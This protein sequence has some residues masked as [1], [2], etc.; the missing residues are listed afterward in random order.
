MLEN[1]Q[2]FIII[3]ASIALFVFGLQSFSKEIENLGTEKLSKWI[4]KITKLPLGGFLLG[5]LFTSIVQSSTLVSTLTVSLVNT[6]I[7]TFRD[8]IL[9]MLGTNIGNTST[10]WIVSMNSSFLGPF[11]IVLG[12]VISMIPTKIAVAGKSV[13]YFGFIFFSLSFISQAMEPIKND[14]LLVNIL[15]KASNPLLGIIYGIII[16]ITIQSS[17]VVVGLVIVLLSQG[18]IDIEVAIPI[19]IGANIGTTSTALLVSLKFSSLS[20]LVAWSASAFNIVGVIIML[21]F[22]GV[23]KNIALSFSDIPA[24]QVA[25]AFTVSNTFTSLFFLLFINPT[26]RRLQKHKWYRQSFEQPSEIEITS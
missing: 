20:K 25:M 19:V 11:F 7:I 8:S 14:P 1:F 24:L 26:I 15:S 23:L 4:G 9:I 21:P 2:T 6:G 5:G 22:F 12:T 18:T 13:F 17:S 16:T 3:I 10:A